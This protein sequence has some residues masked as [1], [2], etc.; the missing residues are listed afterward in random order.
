MQV[1]KQAHAPTIAPHGETCRAPA[2]PAGGRRCLPH[3]WA[4][5]HPYFFAQIRALSIKDDIEQLVA[6]QAREF[7]LVRIDDE[8]EQVAVLRRTLQGEIDAAQQL[9]K[10]AEGDLEEARSEARRLD[11]DLQSAEEQVRTYKDKV[12]AVKTNQELWALQEEISHA[13]GAAS[14]VETGILEHMETADA[15][16]VVIGEGRAELSKTQKRVDARNAECNAKAAELEGERVRVNEL[17]AELRAGVPEGLLKK[18]E[19]VKTARQGVAMAEALDETCLVCNYRMRPQLYVEAFNLSEVIQC[20]HCKRILYVAERIDVPESL[21]RPAEEPAAGLAE[22]SGAEMGAT[23]AA[24]A[25]NH[26]RR[27]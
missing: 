6:L 1:Y 21:R 17:I 24:D 8:L 26:A 25:A 16:E 10:K 11:L 4:L 22:G 2:E 15:L 27:S 23:G 14:D 7:E 12:L 5:A 9:I 3:G 20:E 18:Y 13:E 19:D